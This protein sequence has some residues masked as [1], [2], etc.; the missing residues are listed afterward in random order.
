MTLELTIHHTL[1]N[2]ISIKENMATRMMYSAHL[3]L[4]F[5]VMTMHQFMTGN[6]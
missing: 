6:R 4:I 1:L 2:K 3:F 5:L